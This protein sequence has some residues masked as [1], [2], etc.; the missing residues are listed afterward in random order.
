MN[1]DLISITTDTHQLDG[2]FY[3]PSKAHEVKPVTQIFHGNTMNFYTGCSKFMPPTLAALGY[4]C[5]TYNRRGHD[6]LAIRDSRNIEGGAIQLTSEAI[7]DNIYARDWLLNK[8]YNAPICIGH[9]NGG[10]LATKHAATFQDTPALILLSAHIGGKRMLPIASSKGLFGADK[11]TDILKL[12]KQM[13]SD[14]REDEIIQLPGWYWVTSPRSIIDL[15]QNLPDLLSEASQI[16]CPVLFIRGD[17]EP[18]DLYPAEQFKEKCTST[19]D[20]VVLKNSNHFYVG[21]E[22]E[23][24][25]IVCDWLKAK[26]F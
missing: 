25:R 26:I 2:L 11:L 16:K 8:G 10:V 24:N 18:T 20:I 5:L 6:I 1:I 12:A 17:Q 9:S 14:G 13:I 15:S 21:K 19:V 4:F 23:V 3:K 7:N 22:S